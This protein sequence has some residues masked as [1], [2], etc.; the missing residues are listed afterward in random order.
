MSEAVFSGKIP[1]MRLVAGV[2]VDKVNYRLDIAFDY[3]VPAHLHDTLKRGCRVIIPFSNANRKTQGIVVS[4]KKATDTKKQLKPIMAQVDEEP[5]I[6][7][8]MFSIIDFMVKNTFCTY[9][10]AVKVILPVGVNVD[11]T[12]RYSLVENVETPLDL[13]TEQVHLLEFLRKAKTQAELQ[14]YLDCTTNP[15]KRPIV[16]ALLDRSL[17]TVAHEINTRVAKKTIKMVRIADGFDLALIKLT[18][19]Q[20]EVLA[21]L[22]DLKTASVKELCYLCGI[23]P[24]VLN[25][26]EKK[27]ML[28]YYQCDSVQLYDAPA[29]VTPQIDLELLG[30][31][32]T[33]YDGILEMMNDSKPNVALLFGVTGSGKTQVY[34][35]LIEQALLSG[36]TAMMLV[37]EIALTPQMVGKFKGL[38]GDT[39]AVIHSSLSLAQRLLE[40]NRIKKGGANIVIG[41]RS[42]VFAP[43]SNIGIIVLDEEGEA[44]YK[45]DSPPRYHAREIAKL[46]CVN[47]NATLLLGS[48]T[49]SID[50]Y[51]NAQLGKYSLFTIQARY[52]NASLPSV[53][54]VDMQEEQKVGNFSP[55]SEILQEQIAVNLK[56]GEQTILLINRRG[57]NTYATCM[58]CGEVIKCDSC[59]VAMTYHKANGYLMCHYC[60]AAKKFDSICPSCNG[61]YIKL[62]GAGTQKIED[63]LSLIFK[64]AR[65]LRMDSDTTYGKDGFQKNFDDFKNQRYDIL[66]GT[67]MIAKGLDF[68]NVT[69]VGVIN[70]DS[71]LFSTDFRC[72]ERVFSL[73]TQVV[74]RSGRSDKSGRA[75]IQSR[76]PENITVAY[77]AAQDYHSFYAE[78]IKRRKL[79][80]QP[81][82]CDICVIGFSGVSEIDTKK[83]AEYFMS[84]L[85]ANARTSQ[86]ITMKILG[87]AP[88]S[89][90]K[91]SNKFRYRIILKCKFNNNFKAFL[92][93][94]LKNLSGDKLLGGVTVFVDVNG[95]IL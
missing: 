11:V 80:M 23:G 69:L 88:A 36:K 16:M 67:Q 79:M 63:E 5:I 65:V 45:S 70:A 10:E 26:M 81:P 49:P 71:G 21:Q 61:A 7:T 57:Y 72:N 95:D 86:G 8:E 77:A 3:L 47:N 73:I 35:K 83:A 74:G 48:A 42:A 82:F 68:P 62:T 6:T 20:G 50:S 33:A 78:E 85:I 14:T 90:Y 43:L 53:Y 18:T 46:R 28:E 39:V 52:K 58:E 54:I 12:Q 19:K 91:I 30:E 1:S 25:N 55:L 64:S 87:V 27:H 4:V 9:Y 38:F 22:T 2:Y 59:S 29:F 13:S 44:S 34:I 56:K 41:T 31:Q 51:Y 84:V 66:L 60:G 17:I 92:S 76:D 40:Y 94:T 32:Q 89:I 37:P 24:G 75:Y 93:A 15:A